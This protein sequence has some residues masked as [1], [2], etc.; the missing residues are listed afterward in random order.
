MA[1]GKEMYELGLKHVGEKYSLGVIVPK[2]D[3]NYHGPYDCAE[4]CSWIVYQ[5]TGRLYGCANNNGK[6]HGAD[7]YSQFW[8][9][10]AQAVGNIISINDGFQTPGAVLA[11]VA[12]PGIIGHAAISS[13][14]GTTVEAHS[15][16]TGVIKSVVTGRRWDYAIEVPWI[17]Y[18]K[19]LIP[20]VKDQNQ[21][22][23][24]KIYRVTSPYMTGQAVKN[25]QK[26]LK[27]QR[28][29]GIFGPETFN[30]VRAFQ[31]KKGLVPD[32]EVGPKT[33]KALGLA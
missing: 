31:V 8:I 26:A 28:I 1:T 24:E 22:P 16:K 29:D 3:S 17:T 32:G 21:K 2:D 14:T 33:W 10:D 7:A 25:I 13:G 23:V 15:T 9:R 18:T 27:M 5:L 4:F 6:P 19:Y 30:N 12:M 20:D 11:R